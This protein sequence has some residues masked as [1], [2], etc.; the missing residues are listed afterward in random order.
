[1]GSFT[2]RIQLRNLEGDTQ[3]I[4]GKLHEAMKNDGFLRSI[5]LGGTLYELPE[6]EYN[7]EDKNVEDIEI[8]LNSVRAITDTIWNEYYIL[9]TKAVE[10]MGVLRVI[11]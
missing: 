7:Y 11:Q 8:L 2:I 6:A 4:Y 9:V 10:R 3:E 5:I 1:M